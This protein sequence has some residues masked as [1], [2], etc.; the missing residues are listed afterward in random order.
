MIPT[1]TT[2]VDA[3]L[4]RIANEVKTL[5]TDTF[6]QRRVTV[7]CPFSMDDGVRIS[8]IR[9]TEPRDGN[10]N[11][12]RPPCGARIF[13]MRLIASEA[14]LGLPCPYLRIQN[15]GCIVLRSTARAGRRPRVGINIYPIFGAWEREHPPNNAAILVLVRSLPS[16]PLRLCCVCS[17][18]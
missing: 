10:L 9:K 11:H 12:L 8:I 3:P 6:R 2:A 16:A 18:V 4:R 14:D 13:G 17:M 5:T 15:F 1:Q 7:S